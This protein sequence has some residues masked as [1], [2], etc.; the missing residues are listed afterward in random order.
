M[1]K[2]FIIGNIGSGKTTLSQ[3]IAKKTGFTL[4]SIDDFRRKFNL[5]Q[6]VFGENQAWSV[7]SIAVLQAE[8]C[9]VDC[10]G[11]SKSYLA[12]ITQCFSRKLVIKMPASPDQCLKNIDKRNQSGYHNPPMPYDFDLKQSLYRNNIILNMSEFDII[13]ENDEQIME[14]VKIMS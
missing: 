14:F 13:Y 3:K 11:T 10:T 7:F 6:D 8:N 9:I 4:F 1:A 2:I 12:L 5:T